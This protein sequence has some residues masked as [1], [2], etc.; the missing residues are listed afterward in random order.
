MENIMNWATIAPFLRHALQFGAGILVS[1]GLIDSASAAEAVTHVE[2]LLGAAMGLFAL[3][4]YVKSKPA[5]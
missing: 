4:S 1:R 2:T 5:A 3:V